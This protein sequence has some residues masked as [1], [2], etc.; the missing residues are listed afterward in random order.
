MEQ[1]G[2]HK[3]IPDNSIEFQKSLNEFRVL[4]KIPENN[5]REYQ[6]NL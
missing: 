6:K 4:K 1:K 2:H 5:Q 3:K